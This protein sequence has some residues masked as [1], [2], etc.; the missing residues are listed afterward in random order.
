[1]KENKEVPSVEQ[2]SKKLPKATVDKKDLP[3]TGRI[4]NTVVIGGKALEI[5]PTKLKYHRN[6]TASF[7]RLVDTIPLPDIMMM[8]ADVFGDGRDGDKALMDWLIAVTDD[9]QL[10]VDNYDD[11]DTDTIEKI[12]EIFKR[13]NR[14]DEKEEKQK[15]AMS[16]DGKA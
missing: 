6:N 14:I 11:M 13:V 2:K 9:E 5:K 8:N 15:N 1:M 10:I 4:E 3:Q 12:L 7:Y 16:R